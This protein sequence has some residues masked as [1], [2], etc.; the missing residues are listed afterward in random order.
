MSAA[1]PIVDRDGALPEIEILDAKA[2]GLHETQATA[3]H[4]LCA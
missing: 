2:H 1:F 3:V 4:D